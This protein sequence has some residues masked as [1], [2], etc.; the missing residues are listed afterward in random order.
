MPETGGL[1]THRINSACIKNTSAVS[2]L[3]SREQTV[4]ENIHRDVTS[5]LDAKSETGH[6]TDQGS[7]LMGCVTACYEIESEAG[8][9]KSGILTS[10]WLS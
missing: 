2:V 10:L 6:N 1:W 3:E 4:I 9:C 5:G 8:V 7:F